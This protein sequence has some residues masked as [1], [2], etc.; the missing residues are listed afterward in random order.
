MYTHTV[1]VVFFRISSES[2]I[3]S[4]I[5]SYLTYITLLRITGYHINHFTYE[6]LRAFC[7]RISIQVTD[8]YWSVVLCK[9]AIYPPFEGISCFSTSSVMHKPLGPN[10]ANTEQHMEMYSALLL[11]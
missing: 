9:G 2:F 6:S 11:Q 3:L 4:E 10:A 5:K 1:G 7:F 8:I